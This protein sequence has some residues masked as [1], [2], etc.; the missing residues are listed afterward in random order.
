MKILTLKRFD[1][2]I[3]GTPGILIGTSL[4]LTTL[5]RRWDNNKENESCI[6]EGEYHCLRVNSPKFG[7]TFEVTGVPNRANILIHKGN[8]AATDSHGCILLATGFGMFVGNQPGIINSGDAWKEFHAALSG[9]S[10]FKLII[11]AV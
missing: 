11:K 6:P 10:E 1:D 8:I 2:T 7:D 9:E 4:P 3:W 5:E